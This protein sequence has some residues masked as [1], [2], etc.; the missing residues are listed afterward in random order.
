MGACVRR[1][2]VRRLG[3]HETTDSS[4][5]DIVECS[6]W[7]VFGRPIDEESCDVKEYDVTPGYRR[8]RR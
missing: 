2:N 1:E 4:M 7:D 6:G 8:L 3:T 5:S